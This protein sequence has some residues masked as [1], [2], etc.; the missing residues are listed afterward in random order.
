M[1]A[2][3]NTTKQEDIPKHQ[4]VHNRINRQMVT[5]IGCLQ[6]RDPDDGSKSAGGQEVKT[7]MDRM[8]E[9]SH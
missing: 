8:E 9:S 7:A 3:V 5:R 4:V 1:H 6:S 2:V